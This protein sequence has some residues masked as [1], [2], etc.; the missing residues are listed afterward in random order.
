MSQ[1]F[2]LSIL[3]LQ[4]STLLFVESSSLKK[5]TLSEHINHIS[6]K[7]QVVFFGQSSQDPDPRGRRGR[8]P[9]GFACKGRDLRASSS[10]G[11]IHGKPPRNGGF[12]RGFWWM[13]HFDVC[14][15]FTTSL[16]DITRM[17][18]LPGNAWPLSNF[19]GVHSV[20]FIRNH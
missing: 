13:F 7:S 5:R 20:Q 4:S 17:I 11:K 15:L 6:A 2:I 3:H 14:S 10:N 12:N 18:V 8:F 19:S 16:A 1:L 9:A